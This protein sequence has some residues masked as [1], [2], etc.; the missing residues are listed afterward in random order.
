MWIAI[1]V[2]PVSIV[3]SLVECA[4]CCARH[5]CCGGAGALEPEDWE[6]V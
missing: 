4:R 5:C 3:I 1:I 2:N 6:W